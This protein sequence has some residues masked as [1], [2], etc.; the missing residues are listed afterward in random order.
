M[1]APAPTKSCASASRLNFIVGISVS[2][3]QIFWPSGF[4]PAGRPR[5]P[6][7]LILAEQ[8]GG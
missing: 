6:S 8:L 4:A 2:F 5:N 3:E 7:R 1:A